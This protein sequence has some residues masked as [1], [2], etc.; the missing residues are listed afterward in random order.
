MVLRNTKRLSDYFT[1]RRA[2]SHIPLNVTFIFSSVCASV[3][4]LNFLLYI[5]TLVLILRISCPF[6]MDVCVEQIFS[7]ILS[8]EVVE[9]I[10]TRVRTFTGT[11]TGYCYTLGQLILAAIAYFITDWRW[12]TLAVSLPFYGFFLIAW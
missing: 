3:S 5:S 1:K 11:A 2:K 7:L 10:P 9:W 6:L 4:L 8:H 12:L